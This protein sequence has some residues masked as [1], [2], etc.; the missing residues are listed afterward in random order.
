MKTPLLLWLMALPAAAA[1]AQGGAQPPLGRLFFSAEQRARL[2]AGAER[3]APTLPRA[4]RLDG[5]LR[6]SDGTSTIWLDGEALRGAQKGM[7]I[8]E[9]RIRMRT[10]SG[11][12]IEI[13]VGTTEP[14]G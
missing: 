2:D 10:K 5:I 13:R 9:D 8:G 3:P 12:S 14:P 6:S 1:A 7:W 11:R 4:P